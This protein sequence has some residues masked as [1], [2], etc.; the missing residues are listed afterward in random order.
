MTELGSK[1]AKP[2]RDFTLDLMNTD[3]DVWFN[4]EQLQAFDDEELAW[5][6]E[7][8]GLSCESL[9]RIF[10]RAKEI[11]GQF[12]PNDEFL[13]LTY[14]T[15]CGNWYIHFDP[16]G[17]DEHWPTNTPTDVNGRWHVCVYRHEE[18]LK[19]ECPR[20]PF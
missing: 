4:E 18:H 13:E 7:E 16:P 11:V 19:E 3:Y 15:D 10:E 17:T 12:K 14:D 2:K 1:E 20:D 6:K 8:V 5:F 9:F